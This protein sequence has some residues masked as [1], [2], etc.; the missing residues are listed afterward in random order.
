MPVIDLDSCN[1]YPRIAGCDIC[2]I[3]TGPAGS[4]IARELS[5][6][7]LRVTVL[8]SGGFTRNA[9]TDAL[10]DIENVGHPRVDDQ[11]SVRN[12]IVGGTSDTWG[13][14]CAPFDAIDMETRDWVP[15]SGWP[16]SIEELGPYLDR[17]ALHLGL[18]V[19][20]G[21]SDERFWT[22]ASRKAPSFEPD[23]AV[24]LPFFWQ[25]SRDDRETY[26]YEYMRFGRHLV[27]RLGA[28]VTLV[29]NATALRIQ[30]DDSGRAVRSVEFA[31]PDGRR[32]ILPASTICVCAG[33]IENARILL[34]SDTVTP[35]GLGNDRDV[36]G[37]YLMDHPR[38]PVGSFKVFGSEGLQKRFGRYNVRG[39]LF[40]A[41]LRLSPEIQQSEK[42]LNCA[43]W[44]GEVVGPDDPW[45]ALRRIIR[46]KSQWP[47]DA[48]AVA[49]NAGLLVR[50]LKDYFLEG[51]GIAR[52][53]E[54]LELV[55][56]CEQR[57][58]GESRVTLS[59]HFDRFGVHLPRVDWRTH[60]DETRTMRR[61]GELVAEQFARMG[62]PSLALA[63]WVH[64]GGEPPAF[65]DVAHPIGTT[66]MSDDPAKGVVDAQ[67]R[68]HGIEGLYL[69][70][71]SVFPTASHC[72]P[73]Q[74]IVA[75]ALR[76]ADRL[77]A[78]AE[79]TRVA[80]IRTAAPA[81]PH[82]TEIG[83]TPEG[84]PARLS[85]PP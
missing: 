43:A 38:Y 16:F 71:S 75:L 23:R 29:V 22:I 7:N 18:A 1:D 42:L 24:L 63:P 28:N 84:A 2:I 27:S 3:G 57:P 80:A 26:P 14:R 48:L 50:S 52:K 79:E 32:R 40:R 34:S 33:G 11:S 31:G 36:V 70:G 62:L 83:L 44:L 78:Q 55:C 85:T 58:D 4:A 17:T 20:D 82:P 64:D 72:N 59:E 10:N 39:H 5:G 67:C 60:E 19:G 68:V 65:V 37:R 53:L 47:D 54:E 12:R 61:M 21:F 69:G 15:D 56:M 66:R 6:T 46:A 74:M 30:P 73:T 51:N 77:K 45:D 25:F 81:R 41:G 9:E 8:E 76:L 49:S 35:R 13:G